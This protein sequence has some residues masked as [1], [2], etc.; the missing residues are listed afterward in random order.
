VHAQPAS[1]A[2]N[3]DTSASTCVQDVVKLTE[4]LLMAYLAVD[5]ASSISA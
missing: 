2:S 5:L 3:Y 1:A 4:L